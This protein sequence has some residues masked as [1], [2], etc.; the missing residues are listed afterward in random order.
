ML[1]ELLQRLELSPGGD[2][3]TAVVQLADL[4]MLDVVT[5]HIV[6][7]PYGQGEGTCVGVTGT[8]NWPEDH[9]NRYTV[10]DSRGRHAPS[11]FVSKTRQRT[12]LMG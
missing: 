7:V 11:W 1:N 3:V 8:R 10:Q 9:I 2:V 5:L 6:P 12:Q 4:V